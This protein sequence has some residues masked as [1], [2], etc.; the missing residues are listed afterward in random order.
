MA[1]LPTVIRSDK[2]LQSNDLVL[3][4]LDDVNTNL[5]SLEFALSSTSDEEISA[6]ENQTTLLQSTLGA[7]AWQN[8]DAFGRQRVSEPFTLFECKQISDNAPLFFDELTSGSGSASHSPTDAATTMTVA[9]D[10]D[11]AIRQTYRRFNYQAGKSFLV[12]LTGILGEPVADTVSRIGY[13]NTLSSAP[14][15]S[16]IDG[17]YFESDG[18]TVSF[19]I[20]K[21]GVVTSF[22]QSSFEC[23]CT[24]IDWDKTQI[25]WFDFE[26]LGVGRVRAGLVRDGEF[27]VAVSKDHTNELSSGVYMSSSNHSIRYEIRSTGGSK[28]MQHICST[29]LSEGGAEET[30]IVRSVD[31]GVAS[32]DVD[33]GSERL[34]KAIRLNDTHLNSKVVPESVSVYNTGNNPFRFRL[35]LNPT[36]SAAPTFTALA[37]SSVEEATGNGTITVTGGTV[38]GSGYG[39]NDASV[40][41]AVRTV[42]ALGVS[43]D[44]TRDTIA[45]TAESIA[46]NNQSLFASIQFSDTK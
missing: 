35:V 19:N 21:S 28:S 44:G 37:D 9:A 32:I 41:A 10:G 3:S 42:Q 30:G 29:V 40:L 13:F 45:L 33:A 14:F 15:S 4:S 27:K 6:I 2:S 36:Y 43:I 18:E 46:T 12:L 38:L 5:S 11:Y 22:P 24:D 26:W 20:A 8:L 31:T 34:L 16:D 39:A 17:L 1:I 23:D 7:G 25:F